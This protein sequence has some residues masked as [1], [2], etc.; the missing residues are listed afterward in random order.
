MFGPVMNAANHAAI[1][2]TSQRDKMSVYVTTA[3]IHIARIVNLLGAVMN[4]AVG[5][6][7]IAQISIYVTDAAGNAATS[8]HVVRITPPDASSRSDS[9]DWLSG[10]IFR[11]TST[12]QSGSKHTY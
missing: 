8:P 1:T 7:K 6:V 10:L 4:A 2:A 5:Y 12:N 9:V 11:Q 3:A